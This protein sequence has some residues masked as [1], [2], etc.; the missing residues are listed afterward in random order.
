MHQSGALPRK[1]QAPIIA[2]QTKYLHGLYL[3]LFGLFST[4]PFIITSCLHVFPRP[5]RA[6]AR[7][8]GKQRWLAGRLAGWLANQ[9]RDR[10]ASECLQ[11][12]LFFLSCPTAVLI[13]ESTLALSGCITIRQGHKKCV[14]IQTAIAVLTLF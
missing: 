2:H 14:R 5:P 6:G 9:G 4:A 10:P 13:G 12:F 7:K 11:R 1:L 3:V 8:A